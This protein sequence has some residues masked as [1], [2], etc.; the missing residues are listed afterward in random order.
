MTID[1]APSAI[2]AGLCVAARSRKGSTTKLHP[3]R[4]G[5]CELPVGELA[6]AVA[7]FNLAAGFVDARYGV[8]ARRPDVQRFLELP[9]AERERLIAEAQE[10]EPEPALTVTDVEKLRD[11]V[12]NAPITAERFVHPLDVEK[13]TH[14]LP[15]TAEDVDD[16]PMRKARADAI[17]ESVEQPSEQA[18]DEDSMPWL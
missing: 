9:P 2:A 13:L 15:L 10:L 5:W 6:E 16:E 18:V 11:Q 14:V 12:A 7:A 4:C 1:D 8:S 3:R 17:I